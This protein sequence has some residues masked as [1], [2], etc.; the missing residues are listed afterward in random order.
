V[1]RPYLPNEVDAIAA[2]SL[3]LDRCYYLPLHAL[4]RRSMIQLRLAPAANNQRHG[5][6]WASDFDFAAT[7][8]SDRGAIAQLG[9]RLAGSQKVAGSSPAGSTPA[10]PTGVEASVGA[11]Y[12]GKAA[13]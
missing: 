6:L 1:R 8:S 13:T 5:I 10:P 3:E 9:E 4:Q 12:S 7:L 2:Y 11:A